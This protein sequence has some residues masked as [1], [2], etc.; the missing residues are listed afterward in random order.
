MR[1]EIVEFTVDD[2]LGS[3]VLLHGNIEDI[4]ATNIAQMGKL[5]DLLVLVINGDDL[6]A[7]LLDWIVL[8]FFDWF[9][10]V[11]KEVVNESDQLHV[12]RKDFG[13]DFN[14]P[15]HRE[16]FNRSLRLEREATLS[17][18]ESLLEGQLVVIDENPKK[19]KDSNRMM[20]IQNVK[21]HFLG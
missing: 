6:Q 16:L 4:F 20:D 12:A 8:Y 17:Q 13:E 14:V 19:F 1:D 11:N 2:T 10:L 3:I 21:A 15:A 5:D 18:E 9:H 7:L